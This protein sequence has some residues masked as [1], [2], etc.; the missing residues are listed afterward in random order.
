MAISADIK[1]ADQ[2]NQPSGYIDEAGLQEHYQIPPRTAQ[3]WRASGEG[4]EYV[5]LGKR[6]I[7]YR[8]ADVE[9]WLALRTFRS[10]GDEIARS[11]EAA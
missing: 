11:N 5:R 3:R 9:R 8:I 10:R 1:P 7:L 4:P 6:R 2:V